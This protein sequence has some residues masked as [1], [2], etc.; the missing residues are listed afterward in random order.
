MRFIFSLFI[1]GQLDELPW[2]GPYAPQVSWCGLDAEQGEP[3]ELLSRRRT[4]GRLGR[5]SLYISWLHGSWTRLWET[6]VSGAH[7]LLSLH[8]S[9]MS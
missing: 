1:Q 3:R 7:I 6:S 8:A 4:H 5:R 2:H 9:F